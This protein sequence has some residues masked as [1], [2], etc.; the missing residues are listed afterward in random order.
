MEQHYEDSDTINLLGTAT[1]TI[2]VDEECEYCNAEIS[3]QCD[4]PENPLVQYTG[5][6]VCIRAGYAPTPSMCVY[7]I[8]IWNTTTTLYDADP[9]LLW[10]T[11][12]IQFSIQESIHIDRTYYNQIR[13]YF[14][15]LNRLNQSTYSFKGK[16]AQSSYIEHFKSL[17]SE[18]YSSTEQVDDSECPHIQKRGKG[19]SHVK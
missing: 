1:N 17:V 12:S 11:N 18:I 7:D 15:T 14:E 3:G 5:V 4:C 19:H 6:L 16:K 13:T 10:D 8:T 9:S 2:N